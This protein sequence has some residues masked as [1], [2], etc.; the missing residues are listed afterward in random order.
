MWSALLALA[1]VGML[2]PVRLGVTLLVSS[3]PR[4]LQNLLAYWAGSL[5]MG[6]PALVV[7]LILLHHT[8]AFGTFTEDWAAPESGS[9][10]RY[11]QIGAGALAL[12]IAALIAVPALRR[13]RQLTLVLAPE[14]TTSVL[15]PDSTAPPALS[16]SPDHTP[17]AAA[18]GGSTVRRLIK[19]AHNA[20]EN[21][22][23]WV[24]WVVGLSMGPAP[25]VILFSLA[26]IVASGAAVSTQV[27]AAIVYVLGVLAV[28][29]II[30][31]TYLIAP[32]KTQAA[33]QRL[34]DWTSAHRK[35]LVIVILTVMGLSM[36]AH[37]S[38]IV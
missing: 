28:V 12:L 21:G 17:D 6:I 23:A 24:S 31:V 19:L 4:P 32:A 30:L 35:Q 25:D 3:R 8:P 16:P 15:V 1:V 22:S 34:H 36:L 29:E 18:V 9:A 27:I 11:I 7:P 10:I 33:L 13:Q 5:T 26:I 38:G 2:N 37:G 14:E 20:W